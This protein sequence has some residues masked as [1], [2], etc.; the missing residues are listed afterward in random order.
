MESDSCQNKFIDSDEKNKV[1]DF[2]VYFSDIKISRKKD[3]KHKCKYQNK[4]EKKDIQ[5]ILIG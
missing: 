2:N 3:Q 5:K 4:K 1:R